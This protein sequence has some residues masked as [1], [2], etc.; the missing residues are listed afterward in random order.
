MVARRPYLL[1]LAVGGLL[2]TLVSAQV[3][4]QLTKPDA[5]FAEPSV[6]RYVKLSAPV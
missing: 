5:E 6:A 1:A 3:A 2:P 4:R